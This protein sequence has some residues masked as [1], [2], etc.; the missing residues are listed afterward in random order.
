MVVTPL[1]SRPFDLAVV[2]FLI[3]HI[4]PT[5]ILDAQTGSSL[6]LLVGN[7]NA[8]RPIAP[9]SQCF[10]VFSFFAV[11]PK[12]WYPSWAQDLLTW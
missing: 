7:C 3:S 10:L 5:I 11:L 4:F 12:D 2:V 9:V 1:T 6:P 8:I